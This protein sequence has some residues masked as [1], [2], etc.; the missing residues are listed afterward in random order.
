MVG[1]VRRCHLPAQRAV[2]EYRESLM[3]Q[4]IMHANATAHTT[5]PALRNQIAKAFS[6]QTTERL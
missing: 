2:A 5:H 3:T 1:C 6:C 4:C